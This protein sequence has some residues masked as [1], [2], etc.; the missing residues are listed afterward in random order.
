MGYSQVSLSYLSSR[1]HLREGLAKLGGKWYL[2]RKLRWIISRQVYYGSGNMWI[3]AITQYIL[4]SISGGG[5]MICVCVFLCVQ[6]W[7]KDE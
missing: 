7:W 4:V 1:K 5:F 3:V 2:P 6:D